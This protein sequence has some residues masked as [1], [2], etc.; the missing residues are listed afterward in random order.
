MSMQNLFLPS[1][2]HT[3]NGAQRADWALRVGIALVFSLVAL[4]LRFAPLP[5]N[6]ACFGALSIF[7]GFVLNGAWR[8]SIPLLSLF[9]ADCIGHFNGLPGMGFYNVATMALNYAGF[10]FMISIGMGA[11][12]WLAQRD[13]QW[14][15]W[16]GIVA[17]SFVGSITFFLVSNF[18]AWLDPVMGYDSSVAGLLQSYWMGLPFFRTTILSDMFFSTGFYTAYQLVKNLAIESRW[19]LK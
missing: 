15:P 13:Q 4:G 7:C 18:G 14:I 17:T 6:F 16:V 9:A 19:A 11:S 5:E 3:T 1:Q 12:Y 10:A 2:N 8:W